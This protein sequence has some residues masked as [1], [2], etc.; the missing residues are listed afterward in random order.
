MASDICTVTVT[1]K[2]WPSPF[3]QI[4]FAAAF[5]WFKATGKVPLWCVGKIAVRA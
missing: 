1:F 3:R 4:G 2:L 5:A